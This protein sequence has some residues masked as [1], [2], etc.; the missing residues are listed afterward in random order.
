[1]EFHDKQLLDYAL[2]SLE[3]K[4]LEQVFINYKVDYDIY[5]LYL[6]TSSF[7]CSLVYN[8]KEEALE[9]YNLLKMILKD[10]GAKITDRATETLNIFKIK[11]N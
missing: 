11:Y 10:K 2:F 9:D 5:M 8:R 3:R 4:E 6:Q 7:L 1:M